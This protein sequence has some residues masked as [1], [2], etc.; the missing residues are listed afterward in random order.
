MRERHDW[1]GTAHL[2]NSVQDFLQISKS[3]GNRTNE[4]ETLV[5]DLRVQQAA[6]G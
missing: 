5:G 6:E 2:V 4:L 1:P 3:I